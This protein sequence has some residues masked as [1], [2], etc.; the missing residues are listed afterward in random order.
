[1]ISRIV[2]LI[3]IVLSSSLT[4][5]A[6]T[7]TNQTLTN[8][9]PSDARMN[10]F[11]DPKGSSW[12]VFGV[13]SMPGGPL[14]IVQV[15]EVRQ[16]NPPSKWGV[17]VLN[18]GLMPVNS[19]TLAAAIVDITGKVKATQLL[20]AIRN[21]APGQVQR[22]EMRVIAT[23]LAP[24]DRVVFFVKEVISEIANMKAVDAE[25]AALIKVVA[26]RLPVP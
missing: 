24:T 16:H 17:H 14:T 5:S 3:A 1:M 18:R 9:T 15:E 23:V 20:P 26:G 7:S 2:V 6:Q 12:R 10:Q 4:A 8:P 22:R 25:V 19:L 21:L 13:D 11:E